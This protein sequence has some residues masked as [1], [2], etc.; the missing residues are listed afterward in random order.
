MRLTVHAEGP[1]IDLDRFVRAIPLLL[2]RSR[3]VDFTADGRAILDG[4]AT[5]RLRLVDGTAGRTG[6]AYRVLNEGEAAT[7]TITRDDAEAIDAE[8]TGG[9]VDAGS[10]T[11][12]AGTITLERP[13]AAARV[14]VSGAL[15]VA[16]AP[17]MVG[18]RWDVAGQVR[19]ADWDGPGEPQVSV[20]LDGRLGSARSTARIDR[21]SGGPGAIGAEADLWDV[22][23]D[24]DLQPRGVA[25]LA[26]LALP[27]VRRRVTEA[28]A[29]QITDALLETAIQ[30]AEDFDPE[31]GPEEIADRAWAVIVADLTAPAKA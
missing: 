14:L 24:I 31:D 3:R 23:L 7:V 28:I 17:R 5:D 15:D 10:S 25:R 13:S 12:G 22:T 18:T 9:L 27:F 8:L 20:Q 16:E 19:L 11:T 4:T 6:A 21:R 29:R 26:S 2:D 1:A 30:I